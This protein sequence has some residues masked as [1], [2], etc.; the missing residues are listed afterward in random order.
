VVVG[1]GPTNAPIKK[2]TKKNKK[3]RKIKKA[4]GK[5]LVGACAL[6]FFSQLSCRFMGHSNLKAIQPYTHTHKEKVVVTF[7]F[8]H[9]M[10]WFTHVP[11]SR[12]I[13]FILVSLSFCS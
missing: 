6:L 10:T 12:V 13:F 3:Q 4:K 7:S 11:L 2:Q 1:K 8:Y 5:N 9:H